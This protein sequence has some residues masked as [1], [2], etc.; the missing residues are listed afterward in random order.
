MYGD[1]ILGAHP[2]IL[3][4]VKMFMVYWSEIAAFDVT[5]QI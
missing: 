3:F 2:E 4:N 5:R 1:F